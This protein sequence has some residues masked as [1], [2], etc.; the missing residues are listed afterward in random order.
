[1]PH[2]YPVRTKVTKAPG[3][4]GCGCGCNQCGVQGLSGDCGCGCGGKSLSGDCGCGCGGKCG[5][6]SWFEDNK[7]AVLFGVLGLGVFF[8]M[9]KK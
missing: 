4:A 3:L 7:N 5:M 9:R 6:G 2:F 8:A 1:M